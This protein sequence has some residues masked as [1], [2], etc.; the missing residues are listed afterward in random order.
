MANFNS[1]QDVTIWSE[2]GAYS[3]GVTPSGRLQ[4]EADLDYTTDS[5]AVLSASG[6][7]DI[8]VYLQNEIRAT[9]L[10]I[11]DLDEAQDNIRSYS[12]SGT[13]DFN[14][15]LDNEVRATDL[16]IRDLDEAQDDI[17]IYSASGTNSIPMHSTRAHNR[18]MIVDPT[19][20]KIATFTTE[21]TASGV[22]ERIDCNMDGSEIIVSDSESATKYQLQTE[23]DAIG[24]LLNQS[25]DTILFTVTSETGTLDFVAI[26][27]SN[28]NFEVT[29]E[30]DGTERF[31]I[32]MAEI[33]SIGLSNATNVPLWAETAL[34]NF[35]YSPNLPV[36]YTSGFRILAKSTS[37]QNP[38]VKHLTMYRQR[39]S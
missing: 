30:I 15:Y 12:A 23:F 28:A 29:I 34:K 25:T 7:T 13:P 14:V 9:D 20:T 17:R 1:T 31:R 24:D 16:D 3:T 4:V 2:D 27:G 37:A 5:V 22:K 36:G 8:P 33:G 21:V 26:T 19:D 10:D 6:T 38:T 32:T 11:R 39:V 18:S 35:R